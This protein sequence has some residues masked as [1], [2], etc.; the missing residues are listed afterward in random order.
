MTNR[1]AARILRTETLGD[2]EQ[3]ELAKRM[4]ASALE[5]QMLRFVAPKC[6]ACG[7]IMT[8]IMIKSSCAPL[9]PGGRYTE[10]PLVPLS[11]VEPDQCP[12]CLTRFTDIVLDFEKQTCIL[13]GPK[14]DEA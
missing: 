5:Q 6:E 3:M 14:E 9:D 2:S 11:R 8:G 13:S 12:R 4:G 10:L 7:Y 1:E